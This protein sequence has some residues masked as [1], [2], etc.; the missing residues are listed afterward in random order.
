MYMFISMASDGTGAMTLGPGGHETVQVGPGAGRRA[1]HHV[2]AREDP[3]ALPVV[4]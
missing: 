4:E 3:P 1:L 2:P